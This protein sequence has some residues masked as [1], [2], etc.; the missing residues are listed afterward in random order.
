MSDADEA[1]PAKCNGKRHYSEISHSKVLST[2]INASTLDRVPLGYPSLI[3]S[4]K[5]AIVRAAI[6]RRR[7]A[8]PA[9]QHLMSTTATQGRRAHDNLIFLL[10]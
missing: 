7:R 5:L 3:D 6:T 9:A 1:Q 4:F 10:S 8:A 2:Q